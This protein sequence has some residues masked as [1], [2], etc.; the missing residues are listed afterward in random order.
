MSQLSSAISSPTNTILPLDTHDD[1][2]SPMKPSHEY[3][4]FKQQTGLPTGSMASLHAMNQAGYPPMFSGYGTGLDDMDFKFNN[5][6]NMTGMQPAF[7]FPSAEQSNMDDFID[8]S[9]I[10]EPRQNVRVYPGMHQQQAAMAKAQVHAQHQREQQM[11]QQQ[12]AQVT[13]RTLSQQAGPS[14]H[15]RHASH[16]ALDA[17]QEEIIA[18]TVNQIRQSSSMRSDD[19]CSQNGG[20]MATSTRAK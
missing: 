20:N 6:D 1:H 16:Q 17:R 12:Q 9:A 18:R 10:E 15:K 8:P 2:Q 11:M 14:G 13:Q 19:D 7:F 5:M 4:R 3:E